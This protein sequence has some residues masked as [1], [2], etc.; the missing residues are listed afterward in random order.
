MKRSLTQFF[1]VLA[2]GLSISMVLPLPADALGQRTRNT[3]GGA[4]LGAGA[5]YLIGGS[6]GARTGAVVGAIAGAVAE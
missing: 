5:G 2:I 1:S 4:A 6:S 3:L